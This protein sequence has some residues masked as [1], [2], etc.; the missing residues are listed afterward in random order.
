ARNAGDSPSAPVPARQEASP[1][2]LS[3]EENE[4]AH[5]AKA[6]RLCGGKLSGPGGAADVLGVPRSTLQYRIRKLGISQVE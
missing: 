4:R 3:L 1:A 5:I 2:L 6:L